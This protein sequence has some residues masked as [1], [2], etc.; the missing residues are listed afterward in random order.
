MI[1][2]T[3]FYGIIYRSCAGTAMSVK[4]LNRAPTD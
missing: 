1:K 2:P 3:V 4:I